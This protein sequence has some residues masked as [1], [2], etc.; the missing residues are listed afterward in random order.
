[1]ANDKLAPAPSTTATTEHLQLKT[2]N[3]SRFDKM[4]LLI[5]ALLVAAI[6]L[7]VLMGDRVGVTL[8]RFGPLRTARSTSNI[9]LQ[10][11]ESMNKDTVASRLRVV[12][13]QPGIP[14]D[15]ITESDIIVPVEGELGWNG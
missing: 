1:M 7:T 6:G 8:E 12:E 13:V 9:T 4:V 5:M 14:P 11:S 3:V 2:W 10:F 15:Q